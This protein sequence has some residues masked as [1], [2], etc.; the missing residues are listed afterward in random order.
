MPG[1]TKKGDGKCGFNSSKAE[2]IQEIKSDNAFTISREIQQ[3]DKENTPDKKSD[4]ID[5]EKESPATG[6]RH[7]IFCDE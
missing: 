5:A 2:N 7:K 4:K 1:E 6:A 3:N